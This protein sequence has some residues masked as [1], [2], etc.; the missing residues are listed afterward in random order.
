MESRVVSM[1]IVDASGD[2]GR[3]I[4]GSGARP[5]G[6]MYPNYRDVAYPVPVHLTHASLDAFARRSNIVVLF[7]VW[8]FW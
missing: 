8:C 7:N 4:V 6:V 3:G 1:A 5:T 2:P